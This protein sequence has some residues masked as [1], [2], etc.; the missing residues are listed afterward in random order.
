MDIVF[1]AH[2]WDDFTYW[3]E[4]NSNTAIKN[5]SLLK[6]IKSMGP[7]FDELSMEMALSLHI[8]GDDRGVTHY[9]VESHETYA[10]FLKAQGALMQAPEFGEMFESMGQSNVKNPFTIA[11]TMLMMWNVPSE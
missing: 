7:L 5:Q 11:R 3:V 9:A 4:N 6:E 8:A 2:G 1:T 10:H